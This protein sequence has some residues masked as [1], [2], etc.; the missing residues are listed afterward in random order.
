MELLIPFFLLSCIGLAISIVV[1]SICNGIVPMPTSFKAKRAL[2]QSLPPGLS[3]NVYELGASLGTL[4]LPL[5]QRY[6]HTKVT[7]F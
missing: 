5:A 3:G 6:P 4:L 2:I 1:W 7:G